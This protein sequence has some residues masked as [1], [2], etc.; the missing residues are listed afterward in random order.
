[1]TSVAV[2]SESDPTGRPRS[3]A[4]FTHQPPL[5]GVRGVAAAAVVLYH[6]GFTWAQGGYVGIDLFFTLSGFLI[7]TLMLD[8]LRRRQQL[9]LAAFWRRRFK[10]LL[11]LMFLVV[12]VSCVWAWLAADTS[13]LDRIRRDAIGAVFYVNNWVQVHDGVGYF[14][15][16][17]APTP[18]THTWSLAVE[19]Q[20][21]VVWPLV[22][23]V[24]VAVVRRLHHRN[25]LARTPPGRR[26]W[27]RI[28][29]RLGVAAMAGVALS[30][31]LSALLSFTGTPPDQIYLRT[32]TRLQ[33]ILL[34]C[35]LACL[36]WGRWQVPGDESAD[37][38]EQPDRP[39][40][41]AWD[42]ATVASLVVLAWI[43]ARGIDA[44]FA[45]RGGYLLTALAAGVVI[46]GSVLPG[47]FGGR[48]FSWSPLRWL[49]RI[50]YGVYLWHWPVF[51]ALT[52]RSTGWGFAP[53]T[54]LRLAL[55]LGL[56]VASFHLVETPLRTRIQWSMRWIPAAIACCTVLALVATTG[57]TQSDAD[58]FA[59]D[60]AR[61]AAPPTAPTT[62]LPP[63]PA[64]TTALV[65]GDSFGSTVATQWTSEGPVQVVDATDP[66]CGAFQFAGAG[67]RSPSERRCRDWRSVL[68]SELATRKVDVVV[69][70][71]RTWLSLSTV[72]ELWEKPIVY[73]VSRPQN[74]MSDEL[75][76]VAD[77][78][79]QAGATL[80]LTTIP[81]ESVTARERLGVAVYDGMAAQFASSRRDVVST[82][83]LAS[84]C[85]HPCTP[86]AFGMTVENGASVPS[87]LTTLRIRQIVGDAARRSHL[88][89]HQRSVEQIQAS[90]IPKVL[91]VGDSVAWSLGSYWY[92]AD[93]TPPPD[94]P[95]QLWPRGIFQCELDSGPRVE[96][97]GVVDLADTCAH[98]RDDWRRY[99]DQFDPDV[100]VAV[101]GTWE[102]FDRRI[103]G[104]HLEFG[105][106]EWDTNM[107][108]LL[109]EAVDVLGS[110][111]ATVAF[112]TPPPTMASASDTGTS[113]E[114]LPSHADRFRHFADLL[115]QVTAAHPANTALIDLAGV[116]CPQD[117]CPREVGGV[118]LRPDGIHYDAQ[119]G[120]VVAGW[121]TPHIEDLADQRRNAEE[122]ADGARGSTTTTTPTTTTTTTT[123]GS[124]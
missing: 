117:P 77:R 48:I 97:R 103:D 115:R 74:L 58:R 23:A 60:Q 41:L 44:T 72:P 124:R 86:E 10:R 113:R 33:G 43:C 104:R 73:D 106:P 37:A 13:T 32:D 9:D 59:A 93:P 38:E 22:V 67:G 123:A 62:T 102:V 54:I 55:T 47:S 42:T 107:V 89:A 116:V 27:A 71:A 49:G 17:S 88:D 7:T 39:A 31:G 110:K 78:V 57:A 83:S 105:T 120:P 80:V 50:S 101:L 14:E 122:R 63:P 52:Q 25:G 45:A 111:G 2:G 69:V 61:N 91:L 26:S 84:E 95:L 46:S 20:F 114:W 28:R 1:V 96:I 119:G 90:H 100:V 94:A 11:P 15:Q 21:Y 24:I 53:V 118:T 92:G 99:V 109:N 6:A 98:W 82:I 34:G 68:D 79:Q 121:L 65:I 87:G 3:A 16:F 36:R 19:E 70:V 56:S 66:A 85:I 108:G 35:A 4:R 112:L 51:A 81:E 64:T 18:L 40:M 76:L 29:R 5:D 30:A 75:Q 12:A 8:E